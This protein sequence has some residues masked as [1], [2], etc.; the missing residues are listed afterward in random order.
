MLGNGALA[1]LA[2]AEFPI[3][4]AG[5]PAWRRLQAQVFPRVTRNRVPFEDGD[6]D[7]VAIL[8]A[9]IDGT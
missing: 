4:G 5:S 6:D 9:S 2:L 7:L 8:L 1:Q 3:S